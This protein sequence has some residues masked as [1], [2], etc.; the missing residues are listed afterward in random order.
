MSS[1]SDYFILKG[2]NFR[3]FVK[4]KGGEFVPVGSPELARVAA[5]LV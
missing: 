5:G 1:L 2:G 4:E 3:S